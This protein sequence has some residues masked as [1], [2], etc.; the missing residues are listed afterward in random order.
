MGKR[1]WCPFP[2]FHVSLLMSSINFPNMLRKTQT[3]GLAWG[4][5]FPLYFGMT[6]VFGPIC[7]PVSAEIVEQVIEYGHPKGLIMAPYLLLEMSRKA[8]CLASLSKLEF[9]QQGSA[10]L[11]PSVGNLLSQRTRLSTI[12]GATELTFPPIL[13]LDPEDWGFVSFHT[14]SGARFT[15]HPS[16]LFELSFDRSANIDYKGNLDVDKLLRSPVFSIFPHLDQ[17]RTRDLWEPHPTKPGLW[18]LRSRT[19]DIIVLADGHNLDTTAL[20]LAVQEHPL[21]RT[22]I[23]GG[24]GRSRSFLMLELNQENTELSQDHQK[25]I[26]Q[27]FRSAVEAGNDLYAA[28]AP[29]ISQD[30]VIIASPDRPF[31]RVPKGSVDK[32][33]TFELYRKEIEQ[34]YFLEDLSTKDE[35]PLKGKDSLFVPKKSEAQ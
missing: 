2:L 13:A 27:L 22:A 14:R 5:L 12:Y 11:L 28:T 17:Y 15:R 4:L 19:D 1:V 20:Q 33:R 34:S 9:I 7:C 24:H 10:A 29:P 23:V 6:S 26:Q 8:S 35:C 32:A 25:Q 18:R 16:N 31:V 21:I 30:F 3:G